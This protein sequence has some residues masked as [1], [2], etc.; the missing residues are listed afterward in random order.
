MKSFRFFTKS[1]NIFGTPLLQMNSST[2]RRLCRN[3]KFHFSQQSN[4]SK[5]E[6]YNH[7]VNQITNITAL[8]HLDLST[9]ITSESETNSLSQDI[10]NLLLDM[11]RMMLT[12]SLPG[13]SC[14]SQM[15]D[16]CM[17]HVKVGS[18]QGIV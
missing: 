11:E 16:T 8:S 1:R 14:L 4:L 2:I 9:E 10:E 13:I 7:L 12:C 3:N 18:L 5:V 17:I 6:V 15:K